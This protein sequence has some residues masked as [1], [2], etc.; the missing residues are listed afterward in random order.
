M[1]KRQVLALALGASLAEHAALLRAQVAAG[2]MRRVGVF[3]PGTARDDVINQPFHDEMRRLGW[4]EGQ[5]IV[6]DRVHADEHMDRLPRLAAELVA[7]KP[8]VILAISPPA[9]SAAKQAT[10]TIPIVFAVVV[11]PVAAGL[12]ASLA[13]P[14][15]NATGIT[16]S[17]AESLLPKRIQLLREMLPGVTRIGLLGNT[18]DPGS[19]ADQ[20]ALA[21]VVGTLGLSLIVANG[22]N[23]AEF[24]ASIATL[25][26]QRVQAIVTANGLAVSRRVKMIELTQRARIPVVGFNRPIADAGALFSY[27][28][29]IADQIRRAAPLVDKLLRGARPADIPVEAANRIELVVNLKSAQTL[30]IA[31]P[32]TLLLRADE[33]IE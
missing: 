4:I 24:D 5:N 2:G 33:L 31:V 27:G 30:G 7:R 11:D 16:Q 18:L 12:V 3:T 13:H 28:P 17:I 26:A 32:Q 10:S 8:E 21:P 20:A 19:L 9:S 25:I 23:S 1:N 29:S 14:G 15:G 22:T 6:Y